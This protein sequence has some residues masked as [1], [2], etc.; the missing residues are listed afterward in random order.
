MDGWRLGRRLRRFTSSASVARSASSTPSE[1]WLPRV[2]GWSWEDS[3]PG[4]DLR[5]RAARF[6]NVSFLGWVPEEEIM[7]TMGSFDVFV[8]IEDPD[9]PAYRWASPNK[10]FE[11]MALGRPIVVAAG[12][13]A[14]EHVSES[15]HGLAVRYGD[16]QSLRETIAGF[17]ADRDSLRPFGA[18]GRASFQARWSPS[19]VAGSVC[20]AFL[21]DQPSLQA[22]AAS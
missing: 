1:P 6:P 12:T 15:G 20:A 10:V 22:G 2:C 8:Q 7:K 9:H 11:S 4:G 14:A 18:R 17:A 5:R 3:G 13:V 16:P 21:F 19:R